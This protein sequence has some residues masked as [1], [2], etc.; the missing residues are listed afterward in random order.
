ML[1]TQSI[2]HTYPAQFTVSS[3]VLAEAG[4]ES[5]QNIKEVIEWLESTG[6]ITGVTYAQTDA[7]RAVLK[8]RLK[9]KFDD[10]FGLLRGFIGMLPASGLAADIRTRSIHLELASH[11][12]GLPARFNWVFE[13]LDREVKFRAALKEVISFSKS[14]KLEESKLTTNLFCI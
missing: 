12:Q 3:S 6:F 8:F 9:D 11:D 14:V 7:E 1:A 4:T 13:W 10:Y 5:C 2:Y